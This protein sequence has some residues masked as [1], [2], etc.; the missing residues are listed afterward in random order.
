[1]GSR[2]T[3]LV[4]VSAM[5]LLAAGCAPTQSGLL[6][7]DG[8]SE[9]PTVI[10]EQR[11]ISSVVT[12]RGIAIANPTFVVTAPRSGTWSTS[13]EVGQQIRQGTPIGRIGGVTIRSK[14]SGL[15]V[16][17]PVGMSAKV[18]AG[19]PVVEVQAEGF[20]IH[21]EFELDVAYRLYDD[22][23]DG[24][25]VI[26]NGVGSVKCTPVIPLS[27]TAETPSEDSSLLTV[28]CLLPR[29]TGSVFAGLP[30]T[31]GFAT[32]TA[33]NVVAVP[34]ESVSGAAESGVVSLVTSDGV[35]LV[36]VTLGITDGSWIEIK[37]GLSIGDTI[38]GIA[39]NITEGM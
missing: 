27:V 14:T 20:G 24:R 37:S 35:E 19:I 25:A 28:L 15:V 38:Q 13:V 26:A 12:A 10:T 1:M 31:V 5:V 33:R 7:V 30:A 3:V 11:D 23:R 39:P 4:S 22:F 34:I 18:G 6:H 17:L 8:P 2:H 36:S 32:G 21:A 29:N 16:S 9:I